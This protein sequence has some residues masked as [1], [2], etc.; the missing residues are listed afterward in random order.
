MN[1]SEDMMDEWGYT[2]MFERHVE[3]FQNLV[4]TVEYITSCD[5][6]QFDDYSKYH[7]PMF[8]PAHKKMRRERQFPIDCENAYKMGARLA[9]NASLPEPN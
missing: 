4:G 6:Y 9:G 7:A 3:I 8:D 2:S 5:T 1:I